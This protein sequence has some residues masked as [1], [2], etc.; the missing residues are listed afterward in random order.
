VAEVGGDAPRIAGTSIVL[1]ISNFEQDMAFDE[2]ARLLVRMAVFRQDVI[3]IEK[4]FGH[5]SSAA[6]TKRLLSD[7]LNGFFVTVFTV[8]TK[9]HYLHLK[10]PSIRFITPLFYHKDTKALSFFCFLPFYFC[11]IIPGQVNYQ[12]TDSEGITHITVVGDIVSVVLADSVN[13]TYFVAH[14]MA[15]VDSVSYCWHRRGGVSCVY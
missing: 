13:C 8:F 5:K 11:F 4:K 1:S 7:T 15:F 3:F 10:K 12:E 2:I 9:Y 14:C 6:V